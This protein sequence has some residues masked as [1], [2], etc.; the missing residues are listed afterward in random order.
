MS[1]CFSFDGFAMQFMEA[2]RNH[3][4]LRF[5]SQ[6]REAGDKGRGQACV[7]IAQ[8]ENSRVIDVN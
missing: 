6:Q 5:A 2:V 8:Q 7:C 1:D 3:T 4:A